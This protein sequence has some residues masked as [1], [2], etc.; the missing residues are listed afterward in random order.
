MPNYY[1]EENSLDIGTRQHVELS[2]QLLTFEARE[3][4]L[5]IVKSGVLVSGERDPGRP[6]FWWGLGRQKDKSVQ[7]AKEKG[8]DGWPLTGML[9]HELI[10]FGWG[11]HR[12][13]RGGS[14]TDMSMGL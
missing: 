13:G 6:N 4:A 1:R 8:C 5:R 11:N 2:V 12:K 14:T 9:A 10:P 7:S 3:R